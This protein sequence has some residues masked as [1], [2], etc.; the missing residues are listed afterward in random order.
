VLCDP[1]T[2]GKRDPTEVIDHIVPVRE[3]PDLMWERTN[4]QGLCKACHD[5][6]TALEDSAFVKAKPKAA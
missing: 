4:L 3:R 1:T 6:K 2:S 5:H